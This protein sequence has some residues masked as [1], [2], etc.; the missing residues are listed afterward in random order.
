MN[1]NVYPLK[2]TNSHYLLLNT[3]IIPLC[4]GKISLIFLWGHVYLF[5][6]FSGS[7]S[8]VKTVLYLHYIFLTQRRTD[9]DRLK[10]NTNDGTIAFLTSW[11]LTAIVNLWKISWIS[12]FSFFIRI[13]FVKYMC[14]S[15]NVSTKI[16]F[17]LKRKIEI[18]FLTVYYKTSMDINSQW[19]NWT[20]YAQHIK[21]HQI[22][23]SLICCHST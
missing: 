5:N 12:F 4:N 8:V 20:L 13:F 23:V 17:I 14:F 18:L 16:K 15:T 7:R 21:S 1:S 6:W 19:A 10:R 11:W 9:F 3:T 22:S 2:N